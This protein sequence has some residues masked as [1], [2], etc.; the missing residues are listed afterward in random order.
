MKQMVR[1]DRLIGRR[2]VA[3]NHRVI[4]RLEELRLER[5]GDS[6]IVT[7]YVIGADGLMERLG[8]G[9]RLLFGGK[10]SRGV[11]AR[12]DQMDLS[13]PDRPRITCHADQLRA[14]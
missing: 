7:D 12:W 1:L 3:A 2:V 9:V 11:V 13:E 6:W 4:G 8:L 10:R 14:L 5:R